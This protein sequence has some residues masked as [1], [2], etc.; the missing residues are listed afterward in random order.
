MNRR[1]FLKLSVS[2][3]VLFSI[4]LMLFLRKRGRF[5]RMF[6]VLGLEVCLES[7]RP[8]R[9]EIE[10]FVDAYIERNLS[11]NGIG[12]ISCL[13]AVIKSK[14][15]FESLGSTFLLSSNLYSAEYYESRILKF[16]VLYDPYL[17]PCYYPFDEGIDL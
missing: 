16:R 2:A 12:V 1:A 17:N 5:F 8:R 13:R 7:L 6:M 3:V 10:K 9:A 14:T 15:F 4:P 11:L